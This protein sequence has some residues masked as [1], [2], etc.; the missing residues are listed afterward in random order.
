MTVYRWKKRA[1]SVKDLN[2]H[3]RS[4]RPL[5]FTEQI[6]IKVTSLYCQ[7]SP[8]PGCSRWSLRWAAEYFNRN[9]EILG[10]SVSHSSLQ[11]VLKLHS[12]KPH[13]NRYFLQIT[14]PDFFPKME[15]LVDVYLN[16]PEY[17]FCFDES[18]CLQAKKRFAPDLPV[19]EGYPNYEEVQYVRN[20]TTDV[21]AFLRTKTGEMFVRC[22]PDH[23]TATLRKVFAEHIQ[24]QPEDAE[25]HYICDNCYPHFNNDFCQLIADFSEV[26]YARLKTGK[27][28]REWLQSM[29]KRIVFHFTPFHGSWLNLVEIWFGILQAK[30][31][32]H[33][34]FSSVQQL[35]EAILDFANTW[36][37][38]FAHPFTWTYNGQDLYSKVVRRFT[39][40]LR[41]Q[42]PQLDQKNL[43]KQLLLMS[44]LLNND[45]G[46][47][48]T[49]DWIQL[50][51]VLQTNRD[52]IT[53]TFHDQRILLQFANLIEELL[54]WLNKPEEISRCA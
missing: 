38:Y 43:K 22:T 3:K 9:P 15:H 50:L 30:C 46:K 25:L 6:C 42:S 44:N 37:T 21:M 49:S 35:V 2:D 23:K 8:L 28:R 13:R 17:L 52:Y 27:E 7:L 39:K 4:G 54:L 14:D 29:D 32:R 41:I 48:Q 24:Q 36:N 10:M 19:E 16:P 31:L 5:I 11:R 1:E 18:T 53:L 34:S 26:S 51:E 40:I 20:G 12:L 47:V 45:S 33:G